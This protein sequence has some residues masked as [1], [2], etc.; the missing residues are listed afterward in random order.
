MS[1]DIL[2]RAADAMNAEAGRLEAMDTQSSPGPWEAS[3][4]NGGQRR[5]GWVHNDK[6]GMAFDSI[7]TNAHPSD[8]VLIAHRRN[9]ISQDVATLRATARLLLQAADG[10][11]GLASHYDH[12]TAVARAFLAESA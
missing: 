10:P 9:T 5:P 2:R 3:P 1:S 11:T 6:A 4:R 12:I 8:A 7:A